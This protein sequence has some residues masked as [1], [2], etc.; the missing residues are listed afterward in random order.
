M[1]RESG[2]GGTE[3]GREEGKK[4]D[5]E[6]DRMKEGR[7]EGGREGERER[8]GERKRGRERERARGEGREGI[9]RKEGGREHLANTIYFHVRQRA[10]YLQTAHLTIL[11][12]LIS[13]VLHDTLKLLVILQFLGSHHVHQAQHS[14][15]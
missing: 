5:G 9:G 3:D 1:K 10:W 4:R 15:C 7:R 13:H 12:A 2:E 8:E 6:E 14:G 11:G